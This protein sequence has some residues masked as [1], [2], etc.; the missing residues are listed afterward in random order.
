MHVNKKI[1]LCVR[2]KELGASL[3]RFLRLHFP[4]YELHE[5][6]FTD[7]IDKLKSNS[8]LGGTVLLIDAG[9]P[10]NQ[11]QRPSGFGLFEHLRLEVEY[12]SCAAKV[13]F[14]SNE[15]ENF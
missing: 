2:D 8:E 5:Y 12:P 4:Q 3:A 14:L 15:D 10:H 13:V 1:F 9:E 7:V 6:D 11:D